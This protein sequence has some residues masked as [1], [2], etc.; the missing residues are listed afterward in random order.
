MNHLVPDADDST[1]SAI[2]VSVVVPVYLGVEWISTCL[3]SL[4]KQTLESCR[5]ELILVFNG[6]DDGALDIARRFAGDHSQLQMRFMRSP[7]ASASHARN[8]GTAAARGAYL[9]WIDCDDWVSPEYLELLLLSTRSGR[10]PLAQIINVFDDGS[11]ES[12]NIINRS[13]L[14]QADHIVSPADFHRGLSF[15]TCK[16][17][18]TWMAKAVPFQENLR[19][20]EDVA[21]FAR[22]FALYDFKFNLIPALAGAKYFRLLRDSS[23]SRPADSFDFSI[24]QRLDVISSLNRTLEGSR[25]QAVPLV[26]SFIN[27]QA[28]FIVRYSKAHPEAMRQISD[29]LATRVLAYFPWTALFS[30]VTTLVIAYNFL[31]YADTGAIV[32]G[33]RIR[34]A[35]AP[36]DVVTHKMDN[37][38]QKDSSHHA[39]A[40]PYVQ[41]V[42]SIDGPAVFAGYAGIAQFCREGIL[43]VD[44][45]IRRGR[46]YRHVYS[47]AMWP[48]SHFLAALY[49]VREPS[50]RWIAEFSDPIQLDNTGKFRSAPIVMDNVA[51]DI[52]S[53][54]DAQDRTLLTEN[55]NVYFWTEYLAYVLADELVFTNENQQQVML[56]YALPRGVAAISK[57]SR[58]ANQPTLDPPF[59]DLQSAELGLD[60]RVVNVG[61]FGEF[62][63][64]RGLSEVIRALASVEF[65][66]RSRL[67]IHIFTSNAH[68]A[69]KSLEEFDG[70]APHVRVRTSLGYFPFLNALTQF[71]CLIVNDAVTDGRHEV[72]PYL[73][74]KLSDYRGAGTRVW[75]V[76]EPGS[77]LSVSSHDYVS[78]VGDTAGARRVI[79][80]LAA[81]PKH[82]G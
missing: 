22:M 66:I 29:G 8:L 25:P 68:A 12:D 78:I 67:C 58:I 11:M 45:W 64:T 23:V 3:D 47:R 70:V 73:P 43:A 51:E 65:G 56:G 71:D 36:V 50:V 59:Y 63:S 77:V 40:Q 39:V 32:A 49:K 17:V 18:P 2:E 16:L 48:A 35:G 6:P 53:S 52:L 31:P 74:S 60:L 27:S 5:Y 62:Y 80:E 4:R 79:S 13:I 76:V 10:I 46:K 38:R 24:T 14:D 54:L 61:Y 21:L 69:K 1:R 19:S 33:K 44:S 28:S 72:N 7:V 26:K 9:T 55:M 20:G 41:F 37:V 81:L 15:M 57:K 42:A 34:T 75:A 30:E 82:Q